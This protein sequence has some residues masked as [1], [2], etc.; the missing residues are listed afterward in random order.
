M[1]A[2]TLQ[3]LAAYALQIACLTALA[4]AVLR[5]LPVPSAGFRYAYWRLV[6]AA[7]LVAPWLLRAAP[8][9]VETVA[10]EPIGA[11]APAVTL[12]AQFGA[13]PAITDSG[14][15]WLALAPWILAAGAAARLLWVAIGMARLHRLRRAGTPVVDPMYQELQHL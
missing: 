1:P 10:V 12:V 6:L 8:R 13:V 14:L 2:A 15:P 5:I 11:A 3:N 7:A 9:T 4:A